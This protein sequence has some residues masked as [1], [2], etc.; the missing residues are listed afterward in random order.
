MCLPSRYLTC[1]IA[2]CLGLASIGGVAW[3]K[4]DVPQ[5]YEDAVPPEK[6]SPAVKPAQAV[7]PRSAV[8]AIGVAVKKQLADKDKSAE[9]PQGYEDSAPPPAA[10]VIRAPRA[11]QRS[12]V[13]AI[14]KAVERRL[15]AK[16]D[17]VVAQVEQEYRPYFERMLKGEIAFMRRACDMDPTQREAVTKA[18]KEQTADILRQCAVVEAQVMQG[19][20]SSRSTSSVSDVFQQRL[21]EIARKS[22]RPEQ[23]ERYR[24]ELE[25]RSASR[26]RAVVDYMVARADQSLTLSAQQR[27]KLAATLTKNYSDAWEKCLSIW[28][29]NVQYMPSIPDTHILSLLD[30][31]QR[32]VWRGLQKLGDIQVRMHWMMMQ[33]MGIIQEE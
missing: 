27:E 23:I 8:A 33:G 17:P 25:L 6:K 14:N 13:G 7:R 29:N 24:R 22:L 19:R 28:M 12:A 4:E 16:A 18:G 9:V 26:K 32:T 3:A 31:E 21:V 5:G 11:K 20:V 15:V 1:M 10:A 30:E 2:F